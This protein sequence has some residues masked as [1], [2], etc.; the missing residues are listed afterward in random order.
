MPLVFCLVRKSTCSAESAVGWI[1]VCLCMYARLRL[2]NRALGYVLCV[3]VCV[4]LILRKQRVGD[5]HL[6]PLDMLFNKRENNSLSRH[7]SASRLQIFEFDESW[8][9]PLA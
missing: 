8:R 3:S 1:R 9:Q 6:A 7:P 4:L 2:A 5:F